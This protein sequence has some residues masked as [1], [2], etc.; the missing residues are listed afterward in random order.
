MAAENPQ[1][2]HAGEA[3]HD[4]EIRDDRVPGL[5]PQRRFQLR[6]SLHAPERGD[7]PT[8]AQCQQHEL[9]VVFGIVDNQDF[10]GLVHAILRSGG[11]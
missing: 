4:V 6:R 2:V 3:A 5:L 10:D 1:R 7:E 8:T 9:R 11:S